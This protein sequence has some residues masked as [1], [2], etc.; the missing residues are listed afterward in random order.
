[1]DWIERD[2]LVGA[3][4][5]VAGA[6]LRLYST[7]LKRTAAAAHTAAIPPAFVVGYLS[8][9]IQAKINLPYNPLEESLAALQ[10]FSRSRISKEALIADLTESTLGWLIEVAEQFG[11][12]VPAWTD[13]PAAA[14]AY[15]RTL[16]APSVAALL[17]GSF[18]VPNA[19]GTPLKTSH[20]KRWVDEGEK[21]VEDLAMRVA[22]YIADLSQSAG[23]LVRHTRHLVEGTELIQSPEAL[24]DAV[25]QQLATAQ[26][27]AAGDIPDDDPLRAAKGEGAALRTVFLDACTTAGVGVATG[28]SRVRQEWERA[29]KAHPV[30]LGRLRWLSVGAGTPSRSQAT[31]VDLGILAYMWEHQVFGSELARDVWY[32]ITGTETMSPRLRTTGTPRRPERSLVDLQ[33]SLPGDLGGAPEPHQFLWLFSCSISLRCT[34][35]AVKMAADKV[36]LKGEGGAFLQEVLALGEKAAGGGFEAIANDDDELTLQEAETSTYHFFIGGPADEAPYMLNLALRELAGALLRYA[37]QRPSQVVPAAASCYYPFGLAAS[38][39]LASM[40]GIPLQWYSPGHL[41]AGGYEQ[42]LPV[43]EAWWQECQRRL[44]VLSSIV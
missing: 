26:D 30:E 12:Y 42:W 40:T 43:A 16:K 7:L 9:L 14:Y 35:I 24:L 17:D 32:V 29:A 38:W 19:V 4:P 31:D 3:A 39:A 20:W 34:L 13:I 5:G 18:Q 15:E 11:G 8:P 1:M 23:A 37:L 25:T 28:N 6:F 36:G 33:R 21:T 41:Q 27:A 2:D 10:K 44:P 22:A